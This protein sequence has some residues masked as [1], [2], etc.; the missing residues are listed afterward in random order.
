M[1]RFVP[2]GERNSLEDVIEAV[3]QSVK[4]SGY[5]QG[6]QKPYVHFTPEEYQTLAERSRLRGSDRPRLSSW[7]AAAEYMA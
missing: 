4:W 7:A 5:F 1:L 3:R 2:T 6:F